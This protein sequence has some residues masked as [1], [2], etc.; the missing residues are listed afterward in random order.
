MKLL[1]NRFSLLSLLLLTSSICLN[2]QQES[3]LIA[4]GDMVHIQILDA[5]EL[6][7]HARVTDAGN[8]PLMVGGNV[9]IV[10]MTPQQAADAIGKA[11]VYQHYLVN[12]RVAVNV[13]QFAEQN[14]S[15]LGEVRL[16]GAYPVTA[17]KSVAEA[18]ALAGGLMPDANRNVVIQRHGTGE[19]VTYYSSNSPTT[20]P[21]SAAPGVNPSTASALRQRDT[22]VYPGDIIRVARAEL[23]FAIG[24]FGRPG[25]FSVVNND[26]KLTVLQ[27]VALAGGANKTAALGSA[28]LVRKSPDGKLTEIKLPLGAMQ[29]GKKPDEVLQANDVLYVPFSYLKNSFLGI[30]AVETAAASASVFAF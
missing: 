27:L 8:V 23:V 17:P 21:D 24:D 19:M 12:P 22:L 2:A 1:R 15:V 4:P 3:M 25:G 18:L 6:E 11:L 14:I 26:A 16:P 5:P 29:K 10:S 7:Q 30:S 9:K 20:V 28:R 13:E